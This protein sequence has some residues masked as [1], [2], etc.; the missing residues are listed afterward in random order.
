MIGLGIGMIGG[1]A[2][3]FFQFGVLALLPLLLT[4]FLVGEAVG[5]VAGR[6]SASSGLA[7]VA[8]VCTVVGPVLGRGA[9]IALAAPVDG[10]GARL[11]TGLMLA[12]RSMAGFELLLLLIAGVLA[13]TRVQNR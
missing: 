2:L 6:F 1:V 3:A 12:A 8:F 10:L 4:G 11:A 9:L 13:A 5:A 7:G